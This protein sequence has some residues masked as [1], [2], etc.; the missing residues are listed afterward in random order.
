MSEFSLS[1]PLVMI[2]FVVALPVS[3][4]LA[5][6]TKAVMR[7]V[8]LSLRAKVMLGW[9]G[10]WSAI[11][12]TALLVVQLGLFNQGVVIIGYFLLLLFL[13]LGAL[14]EWAGEKVASR[15]M[16]SRSYHTEADEYDFAKLGWRFTVQKGDG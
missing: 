14:N 10:I 15:E 4:L 11:G 13:A 12:S 6:M 16:T 2:A 1:T 3:I 7:A 5:M 8:G 9:L